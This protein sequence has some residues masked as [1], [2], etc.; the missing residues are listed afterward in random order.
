MKNDTSLS[1][2]LNRPIIFIDKDGT[3]VEDVPYNIDP[4]KL[5]FE[6]GAVAGL[7]RLN[8][9]GFHFVIVTNQSGV[10]R[11]LFPEQ[12]LEPVARRLG[13]MI[14]QATGAVIEGFYYC[15][16]HPQGTVPQYAVP[17]S[18]RKPQPGMLLR[19]A[20]D[21]GINLRHAWMV[22]DLLNDIEAGNRAG[23][24]T[25]LVDRGGE[26]EWHPG[27]YRTPNFYARDL[28]G[29]AEIIL[30]EMGNGKV[31]HVPGSEQPGVIGRQPGNRSIIN[32]SIG[33]TNE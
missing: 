27:P 32:K 23:C 21:L 19:A 18:C 11:G 5:V 14:Q 28:E 20:A 31:S 17:C 2:G 30:T 10:A 33:A 13:E 6:A 9:A 1:N 26:T 29:A 15:P 7:R 3:L 22:G 12:A 8:E 4:D 16:H 24:R 25:I